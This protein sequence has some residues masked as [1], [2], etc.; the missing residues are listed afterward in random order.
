MTPAVE[1]QSPNHWTTREVP[2]VVLLYLTLPIQ[3]WGLNW[4]WGSSVSRPCVQ[5]WE[6]GSLSPAAH[7][8]TLISRGSEGSV[9]HLPCFWTCGLFY[10]G[11]NFLSPIPT[12]A[13]SLTSWGAGTQGCPDLGVRLRVISALLSVSVQDLC[14]P[15]AGLASAQPV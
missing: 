11:Y 9:P 2:E 13:S 5:S 8:H 6:E 14:P 3:A 7:L 1:R 10:F 12:A 4:A 15:P